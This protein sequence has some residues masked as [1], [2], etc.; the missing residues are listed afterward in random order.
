MQLLYPARALLL[1]VQPLRTAL[2]FSFGHAGMFLQA[3]MAY[4][5]EVGEVLSAAPGNPTEEEQVRGRC[6]TDCNLCQLARLPYV[7]PTTEGGDQDA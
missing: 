2:P 4:A 5:Q 7:C 1:S 3:T 6:A